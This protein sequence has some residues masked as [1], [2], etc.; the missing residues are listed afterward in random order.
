MF[1]APKQKSGRG[2]LR[3]RFPVRRGLELKGEL[4]CILPRSEGTGSA[5]SLELWMDC[6]TGQLDSSPGPEHLGSPL[7]RRL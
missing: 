7:G 1:G 2:G 4:G 3:G 5:A 6:C